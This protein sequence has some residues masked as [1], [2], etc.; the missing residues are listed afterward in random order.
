MDNTYNS[1]ATV[2]VKPVAQM[3]RADEFY[4][5]A[6]TGAVATPN[7]IQQTSTVGFRPASILDVPQAMG[8]KNGQSDTTY[9]ANRTLNFYR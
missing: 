2:G 3:G 5:A 7:T 6:G 1:G 9:D 8:T 4:S